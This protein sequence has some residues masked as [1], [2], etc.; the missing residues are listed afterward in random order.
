MNLGIYLYFKG[1]AR[2]A[3]E[4]YKSVFG[5]ELT[6]TPFSDVPGTDPEH[7]DWIMHANLAGG[8]VELMASDSRQ[9]SD[10]AA[11]IELTLMGTDDAKIRKAFDDLGE[12]GKVLMPLEKQSWGDVYGKVS[13]KYNIDWAFNIGPAQS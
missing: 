9:A 11:K 10:R 8:D 7:P 1:N 12:G 4:F 5:G 6:L 13:D 3:M 2:E